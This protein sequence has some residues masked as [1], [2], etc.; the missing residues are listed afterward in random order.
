[1][2]NFIVAFVDDGQ[3]FLQRM[4]DEKPWLFESMRVRERAKLL[5][6]DGPSRVWTRTLIRTRDGMPLSESRDQFSMGSQW[7]ASSRIYL[8]SR[9]DI[10]HVMVLFDRE[11][12]RGKTLFQLAD[13]ATMR[14]LA[15]TKPPSSEVQALDTILALFEPGGAALLG[16][17]DFDRAYLGSVYDGI[18]NINGLSKVNDV[19]RRLR[20]LASEAA[21]E[22]GE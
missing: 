7:N 21:V 16:L 8:A 4:A 13:Y 11:R 10:V 6:E 1:M 5:A 19:N 22:S 2:P 20:Q 17:T 9:E 14:G 15:R 12:V 3:A 18:P